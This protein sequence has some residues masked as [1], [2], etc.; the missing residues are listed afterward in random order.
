[1]FGQFFQAG[2]ASESSMPNLPL[3]EMR[4]SRELYNLRLRGR[5]FAHD[6]GGSVSLA[7]RYTV[8]PTH[9]MGEFP[10]GKRTR[11]VRQAGASVAHCLVGLQCYRQENAILAI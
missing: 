9:G 4:S 11:V 10:P 3:L 1:M 7:D 6:V 5:N 8:T 2:L